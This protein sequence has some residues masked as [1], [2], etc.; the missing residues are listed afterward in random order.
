MAVA[1]IVLTY[2]QDP[3]VIVAA[4]LHDIVEDTSLPMSYVHA[5]FGERVAS[6]VAHVTKLEEQLLRVNLEDYV[7]RQRLLDCKD[8][9]VAFIKLADRLHNMRTLQGHSSVTKRKK[10]AEETLTFFVPMAKNLE[11]ADLAQELEKRSIEVL[12]STT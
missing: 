5:A 1:L 11:L 6:L 8:T 10:I 4:L 2:S 7:Q 12:S 9:N 3:D